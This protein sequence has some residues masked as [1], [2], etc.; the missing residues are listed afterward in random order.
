MQTHRTN[1]SITSKWPVTKTTHTHTHTQH[2]QPLDLK[3]HQ[4]ASISKQLG[5]SLANSGDQTSMT[6]MTHRDHGIQLGSGRGDEVYE[7]LPYPDGG[8]FWGLRCKRN[9]KKHA[10]TIYQF[11]L[12]YL[13]GGCSPTAESFGVSAQIGSGV[14]RGNPELRFHQGSTRGSTKVPPGFHQGSTRVPPGFHQVPPAF[15][16]GFHQG[17]LG[18][19]R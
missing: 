4:R 1:S 19:L 13:D 3:N 17:G 16:P 11:G 8:L 12:S 7:E 14:V 5:A 15:P 9:S 6:S 18:G 2:T 10:M